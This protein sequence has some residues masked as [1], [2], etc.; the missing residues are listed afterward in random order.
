MFLLAVKDAIQ[1]N[2]AKHSNF[3]EKNACF[4]LFFW[5]GGC[6]KYNILIFLQCH[7]GQL[8]KRKQWI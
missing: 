8:F 7:I 5:G 6:L 3:K 1:I 2:L 4:L